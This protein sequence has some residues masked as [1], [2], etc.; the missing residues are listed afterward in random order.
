MNQA[1]ASRW[2]FPLP[3]SIDI[4]PRANVEEFIND[5]DLVRGYVKTLATYQDE[6]QRV[7]AVLEQVETKHDEISELIRDY[8][9]LSERI[10]NQIKTIQTMYQEFTNLE[11]DQY[12]LLSNNF[13][14]EFL[15]TNKLQ[16]MLDTSHAE[17]LAVA[18]RIQELG[19]FEM[20]A[21]FRDARKKYHLRKEKLNRWGE[22][23]VSG[24]V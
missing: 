17:S 2:L 9:Q 7:V 6:R 19:D 1:E 8:K 24:V 21:E 10:V 16:G 15:I 14:Q 11:I 22:E 13:N 5:P 23:R 12:R 4:L 20:L 3:K 18:K